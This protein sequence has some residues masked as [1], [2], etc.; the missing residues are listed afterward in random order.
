MV[1]A[2]VALMVAFFLTRSGGG[3]GPLVVSDIGPTAGVGAV[4]DA[5]AQAVDWPQ[6][7]AQSAVSP[8]VPVTS[9]AEA[10]VE[11]E[12]IDVKV[13][14]HAESTRSHTVSTDGGPGGGA[15]VTNSGSAVADSGGNI[16]AS[17]AGEA[18]GVESGDVDA[19]GNRST[20]HIGP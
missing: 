17:Q 15:V 8:T 6:N 12:G 1:A 4:T 2:T 3:V 10:V 18:T 11:S 5:P 9:T 19:E 16:E 14:G 20:T 7:G 13:P